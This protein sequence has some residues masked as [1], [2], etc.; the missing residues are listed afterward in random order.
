MDER[1]LDVI[2]NLIDSRNTFFE[3][4]GQVNH[5]DR[6][7]I[8]SRFMVNEVCYLEVLNRMHQNQ[9]RTQLASAVLSFNIPPV[10]SNFS[11]PVPIIASQ[12]QITSAIQPMT[13]PSGNCAICQEA[14]SSSGV[15]LTHC[16]HGYHRA[17]ILN[18]FSMSVRCPV[19]RHDIRE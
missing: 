14:I 5:V 8:V 17:C 6:P 12:D 15:R 19:C 9:L 2:D 18:W 11:D 7:A 13:N 10:P 16:S 3:R 1:I 4:M